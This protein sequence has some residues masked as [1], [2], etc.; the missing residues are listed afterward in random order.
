MNYVII[1]N[2]VAGTTAAEEIR[3][4]DN[5]G[6]IVIIS[7][8][9]APFY[10]RIRL[11][12]YIAGKISK[13]DLKIKNDKWYNENAIELILNDPVVEI[14]NDSKVV[15]TRSNKT[16]DYDRLLLATGSNA[17]VPPIPGADLPGVFTLRR[18][19]DADKIL[20]YQKKRVKNIVIIGGGVLGLEVGNALNSDTANTITI[21]EAFPR[22]LPRQMDI[23]GAELLKEQLESMGFI[24]HIGRRTSEIFGNSSVKGIR[25]DDDTEVPADMIVI[26]AGIR[27]ALDLANQLGLKVDKGIVVDDNL[28]TSEHDIYAAG[29]GIIHNNRLYGI[30]SASEEQGRI[31]AKNMMGNDDRYNGTILSNVLKVVGIDLVSIGDIDA[32]GK[33]GSIVFSDPEKY[34]YKKLV[35]NQNIIIG[36]IFYGDKSNWIKVKNAIN[37]QIDISKIF[38]DIQ[39][40][41]LSV[42]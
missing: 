8:E 23:S 22:L 16:L 35:M 4:N 41:D 11:I 27:P 33:Y 30:W 7:D 31:A 39:N 14:D 42:L 32:E 3:K 19:S 20:E 36:A 21:I 40:W 1:G 28:A 15:I 5:N 34:I 38:T 24:F 2:G 12:D 29:D 6:K 17:F 37:K 10:S 9:E 18:L 26:S 13:D 25:L